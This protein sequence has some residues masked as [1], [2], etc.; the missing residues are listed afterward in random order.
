MKTGDYRIE[1]S[2]WHLLSQDGITQKPMKVPSIIMMAAWMESL[3]GKQ[4]RE[5]L[6]QAVVSSSLHR[7]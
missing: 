2:F 6:G 4:V 1:M 5:G 3:I 7:R